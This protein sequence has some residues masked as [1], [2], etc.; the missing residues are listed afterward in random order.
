MGARGLASSVV[1]RYGRHPSPRGRRMTT[2]RIEAYLAR[3]GAQGK[4]EVCL[5]NEWSMPQDE[6]QT[7]AIISTVQ[8]TGNRFYSTS[9]STLRAYL[10]VCQ[11]CG[12]IRFHAEQVV[13][14][15]G[16]L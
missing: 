12:N 10:V 11:N 8:E 1:R 9:G 4:C 2:K 7:L 6:A 14:D 15:R 5:H 13:K 16:G 3:V